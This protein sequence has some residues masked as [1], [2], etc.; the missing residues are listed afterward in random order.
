MENTNKFLK[1]G[2]YWPSGSGEE[3]EDGKFYDNAADDDDDAV[4]SGQILI[5]KITSA[6]GSDELKNKVRERERER[7]RWKAY[8]FTS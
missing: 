8:W 7:R 1:F 6:V 3:D 5:R 2:C 4:D